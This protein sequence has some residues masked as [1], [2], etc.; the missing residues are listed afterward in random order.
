MHP[1]ETGWRFMDWIH[2]AKEGIRP[3]LSEHNNEPWNQRLILSG[4]VAVSLIGTIKFI[5]CCLLFG[6]I[7]FRMRLQGNM[8]FDKLLYNSLYNLH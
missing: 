4:K 7:I 2:Y 6:R 8:N 5:N 3:G 1:R